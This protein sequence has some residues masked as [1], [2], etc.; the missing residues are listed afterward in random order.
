MTVPLDVFSR[1]GTTS[2]WITC[3]V[4]PSF[5]NELLSVLTPHNLRAIEAIDGNSDHRAF[6]DADEGCHLSGSGGDGAAERKY[7]VF[8]RL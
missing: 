7:I 3:G 2:I 4:E 5:W 1:E 8:S 6:R